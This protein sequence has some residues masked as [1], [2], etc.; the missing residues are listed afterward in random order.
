MKFFS[1]AINPLPIFTQDPF[2]RRKI[3]KKALIAS[4]FISIFLHAIQIHLFQYQSVWLSSDSPKINEMSRSSVIEKKEKNDILKKAFNS[5]A[6]TSKTISSYTTQNKAEYI[7]LPL[8]AE[9]IDTLPASIQ[10]PTPL[11]ISLFPK[12]EILSTKPSLMSPNWEEKDPLFNPLLPLISSITSSQP[13]TCSLAPAPL[14]S[15]LEK[16]PIDQEKPKTMTI[17]I[18]DLSSTEPLSLP[19]ET[20][21]SQKPLDLNSSFSKNE[22]FS[23]KALQ[24][25]SYSSQFEAELL[26][27]EEQD[28]H[29]LFAVTLVPQSELQFSPLKTTYYFLI[30]KA[31]SI[32]KERL[33]ATK[34]AIR[35]AID[36]LGDQEQFNII[37]FDNKIEKLF[38]LPKASSLETKAKAQN[39]LNKLEL[40]SFFSKSDLYNPLFLTL[41]PSYKEDELHIALLFSDGEHLQNTEATDLFKTWSMQN[42]GRVSLYSINLNEDAALDKLTTLSA[43]N[44]GKSICSSTNRGLKRKLLKLM[45]SIQ[46]PIA[47][48]LSCHAVSTSNNA[49]IEMLPTKDLSPHLF[50]NE[51]FTIIGKTNSLDDMV[52]FVQGRLNGQWMHIK[53]R[54][55]FLNAKKGHAS[56][57]TEWALQK[58]YSLYDHYLQKNDAHALEEA[59]EI[60]QNNHLEIF[61]R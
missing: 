60:A 39:F 61:F 38:S 21:T 22:L 29:Y 43:L 47:T 59:Q 48:N 33:Q 58:A 40:G 37:A 18:P 23:L 6:H 50:Q 41:P 9:W 55:S 11:L 54:L 32:Q 13:S 10:E 8:H 4:V 49:S 16:T 57:K 19:L 26:F 1:E 31:N 3:N 5:H 17:P 28:G 46:S 53:K 35:K 14:L 45:K 51:P 2:F 27:V 20:I 34:N 7:Q 42:Q 15:S 52:L 44:K 25:A 30:D 56:L 24:S 12:P 36:E